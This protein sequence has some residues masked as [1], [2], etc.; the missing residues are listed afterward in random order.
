MIQSLIL[1]FY[2]CEVYK[3]YTTITTEQPTTTMSL[4]H[5][6]NSGTR[7]NNWKRS[8]QSD[9]SSSL[10][11]ASSNEAWGSPDIPQAF[12]DDETGMYVPTPSTRKLAA[13]KK[14]RCKGGGAGRSWM[15]TCGIVMTF[16]LVTGYTYSSYHERKMIEA[17]LMEQDLTMR[18]L[19]IEM[20]EK[21]ESK[22][23]EMK[24]ENAA[25][26]RQLSE[27][28]GL[29]IQISSRD[30]QIVKLQNELVLEKIDIKYIGD[31]Y[32]K[33]TTAKTKLQQNIQNLS[34]TLLLEKFGPGPHRL[35]MHIRFDSHK[36]VSD[37]GIIKIEMAPIVEMPHAV[38]WFLEQVSRKLYDGFSFHRNA[39]HVI[40]GGPVSNFLTPADNRPDEETFKK[41]GFHKILFQEYSKNFP[42]KK[43]TIGFGGRPGGPSFYI[44]TKDNSLIHG[45]GGQTQNDDPS[46]ADTCFA[47]VID[48]FEHVE[49]IATLPVKKGTYHSLENN[50]AIVRI[51][52]LEN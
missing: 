12:A 52:L 46:E 45:P 38:Y 21:F 19:E 51:Q 28:E 8:N 23:K 17:Q 25:L 39:R 30:E 10:Y 41:A 31:E 40:E 34:K 26:Q 36:G 16:V 50:V 44:N 43:F 2:R 18:H 24:N 22:V 7:R 20:S 14:K 48:G 33:E 29:K 32:K 13:D 11:G 15:T 3:H 6:T 37:E 42:H 27:Q 35:E 47:K 9:S 5:R 4:L 49:R 1:S